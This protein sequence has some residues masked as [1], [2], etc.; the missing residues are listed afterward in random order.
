VA[1]R[2]DLTDFILNILRR[3]LS[4]FL[5]ISMAV[6]KYFSAYSISIS[7]GFIQLRANYK[8]LLGTVL[9]L[10]VLIGGISFLIK[11][12]E[13]VKKA[14]WEVKDTFH[15]F[16]ELKVV[17][18]L[19][20]PAPS[21]IPIAGRKLNYVELPLMYE[22]KTSVKLYT[23]LLV[24][25]KYFKLMLIPYP[26]RFYYGYGLVP[27]SDYKNIFVWFSLLIHLFLFL[28]LTY[29]LIVQKH[30]IAAFGILFYLLSIIPLSNLLT[31]IAGMMAER[32][33][34]ASSLGF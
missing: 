33:V 34:Y 18:A 24:L 5:R 2:R 10:A 21:V 6:R 4:F 22:E 1:K 3:I 17:P 12:K 11:K 26:L 32:L 13:Q 30:T 25:G 27:L 23:S 31:P 9:T 20:T 28:V 8:V 7:N 14:Q 15:D 16:N 29:F 19:E